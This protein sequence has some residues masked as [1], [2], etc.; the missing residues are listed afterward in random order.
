MFLA[1]VK[2][3]SVRMEMFSARNKG[4]FLERDPLN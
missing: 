4:D 2:M 3:F 1:I